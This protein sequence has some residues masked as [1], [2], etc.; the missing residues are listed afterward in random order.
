MKVAAEAGRARAWLRRLEL[1]LPAGTVVGRTL[2]L[3]RRGRGGLHGAVE[4]S[5]GKVRAV[6][7]DLDNTLYPPECG[8][9]AAGDARITRFIQGRLGLTWAEA[10]ELRRR[11]WREYG[12]T[13]R[14]LAVEYGIA[15]VEMCREALESME[16]AEF[17]RPDPS[18][19]EALS[20]IPVPLYLFTNSTRRYA[21]K[22]MEALGVADLFARIFDIEFMRW[23]GKPNSQAFARVLGALELPARAVV[24]V[25][26]HPANLA[27]AQA[28]GMWAVAVGCD[29]PAD[30]HIGRVQELSAALRALRL[31]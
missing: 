2:R 6:L 18:L 9:L 24:L 19:C 30:W 26:D 1:G 10:D 12:T 14:G 28:I 20:Q 16:P 3:R 27:A 25:D 5:C 13:A 11:L 15:E 23:E 21:E 31:V 8:L 22:I 17:L 4:M 7:I 29:G